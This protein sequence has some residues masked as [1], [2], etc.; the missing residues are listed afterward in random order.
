MTMK[1]VFALMLAVLMLAT[2]L[3]GCGGSTANNNDDPNNPNNPNNPNKPN[4]PGE[5]ITVTIGMPTS[6]RVLDYKSNAYTLW[7]E[8][9]TGYNI[10]F[11]P[12]AYEGA[13]HKKQLATE[14]AAQQKLPDIL[15]AF[16]LTDAEINQYGEDGYF[17]DLTEYFEDREKSANYWYM[18]EKYLSE[19]EQDKVWKLLHSEKKITNVL[20][21]YSD[22]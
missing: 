15:W 22:K 11:V 5:P 19:A 16:T 2:L 7:L 3:V 20:V 12:Y 10:E 21:E 8:E 18:V 6:P 17:I 14:T 13:D 4:N 9:Q 1:K